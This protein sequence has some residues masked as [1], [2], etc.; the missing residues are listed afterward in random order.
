MIGGVKVDR[1]A[2]QNECS[3]TLKNYMDALD[4]GTEY[5]TFKGGYDGCRLKLLEH[6]GEIRTHVGESDGPMSRRQML[7]TARDLAEALLTHLLRRKHWKGK[8][9][10]RECTPAEVGAVY[11]ASGNWFHCRKS[12]LWDDVRKP[13][14]QTPAWLEDSDWEI[15]YAGSSSSTPNVNSSNIGRFLT[16]IGELYEI[17]KRY[18]HSKQ[19]T[20]PVPPATPQ[21]ANNLMLKLNE[22]F[23]RDD[24][25]PKGKKHRILI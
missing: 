9:P 24:K 2:W 25:R 6:L 5:D 13:R 21:E 22:L 7:G 20:L 16:M 11:T 14:G 17:G 18:K 4:R 8:K 19:D 15:R 10:T 1:T 23:I 12:E 3:I